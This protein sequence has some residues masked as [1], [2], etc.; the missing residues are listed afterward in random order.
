VGVGVGIGVAVGV[1][2]GL[3]VAVA[4][5]VG[6][7]IGSGVTVGSVVHAARA[8]PSI[9]SNSKDLSTL[10]E[11]ISITFPL[12]QSSLSS[13]GLRNLSTTMSLILSNSLRQIGIA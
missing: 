13:S 6:V 11:L 9:P 5:G 3:G 10:G 4:V 1:G 7:L 2:V 12:T 8:N